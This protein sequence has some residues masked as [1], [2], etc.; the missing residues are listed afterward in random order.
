MPEQRR[1]VCVTGG[2]GFIGVRL[3]GAL[4][5][6]GSEVA[7][8][9]DLSVGRRERLPGGARLVIGDIRDP[10]AVREALDGCDAVAHL[11]AAMGKRVWL[12]SRF[13]PCWR[14]LLGRDDTPWYPTMR[15]YRQPSP[16]DW[17]A[18]L[19]EVRRDLAGA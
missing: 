12:L 19:A 1:R 9:D 6:R 8:L 2:A 3:V 15:V 11:A 7:V 4:L 5:E 13:D 10:H 14:W 18:V 16:G 17:A